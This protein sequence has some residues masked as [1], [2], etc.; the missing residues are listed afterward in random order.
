MERLIISLFFL[1][2]LNLNAQQYLSND[3]K[4]T[5]FSEAPLENISAVNKKVSAAYDAESKHLVFQLQ[6]SDFIFPKP[7]MQEHFNENYL[8]SDIYPKSSFSGKIISRVDSNAIVEGI[9]KIHGINNKIRVPGILHHSENELNI[10]ANFIVKLEDY[11]IKIP[12]L[13]LYNIAEEIEV[14]VSVQL[15]K[16]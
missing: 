11:N 1:S 14:K 3:G 2:F 7:L 9:L 10:S 8:E 5:F 4:I 12:K 13:V 16:I 6:I 15:K